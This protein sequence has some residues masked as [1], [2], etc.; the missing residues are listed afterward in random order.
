[1]L[2]SNKC[3]LELEKITK[4][5][6]IPAD[7]GSKGKSRMRVFSDA[8]LRSKPEKKENK[9]NFKALNDISFSLDQGQ[10]LGIIGLNGSG[11]STLLQIISGTLKP[12]AGIVKVKNKV[13]ALL[14]LGAGFNPDFTGIENIFINAQLLGLSVKEIKEG[15]DRIIGFADIGDFVHQPVRTYSSG[16]SVRLAFAIVANTRPEIL[17]IDEALAVGDARF[18]AKCF[19][20]LE[21]FTQN[22][23]TLILVSHDLNSI[24]RLCSKVVL[25]DKGHLVFSGDPLSAINEYS[26]IITRHNVDGKKENEPIKGKGSGTKESG[27]PYDVAAKKTKIENCIEH[28]VSI[29]SS[30]FCYGGELGILKDIDLSTDSEKSI[31]VIQSGEIFNLTFRA[32]A[33]HEI[34][35]PIFAMTI[36]DSK[37]QEVYGQNTNFAKIETD[38]LKPGEEVKVSFTQKA[39]FN[40][41]D[42]LISVG[43]TKFNEKGLEVIHR[44]YDV[45]EFKVINRDGSFGISNCF[46]EILIEK[47][48]LCGDSHVGHTKSEISFKLED[49]IITLKEGE[50][51]EKKREKCFRDLELE[52]SLELLNQVS[53]GSNWKEVVQENF[54][55][56]HPWLCDIILNPNRFNFLKEKS[57]REKLILDIGSGWGQLSVP[58]AKDNYVCSLEPNHERLS[59][60][61]EV[62]KQEEVIDKMHFI[63]ADY[64]EVDFT[65][66]FDVILSV[67]VLEWV[68]VFRSDISPE[69][70]QL[71]FLEKVKKDL[72][73]QG[74]LILGIENRIGLKYILGANDDH[75]GVPEI[76]FLGNDLAKLKYKDLTNKDLRTFTYSLSEYEMLLKKAGFKTIEFTVAYP[77]YKIPQKLFPIERKKSSFNEF[78]LREEWI[79]EHDGSNGER[80]PFQRELRSMYSTLAHN[81]IAHYFAPS[82]Y[83]VAS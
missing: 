48:K 31:K 30:G 16:M 61:R 58:L 7:Y 32:I 62:A 64:F 37:G 66:T 68:G 12:S 51:F 19:S 35:K 69:D 77:D 24:S 70:V 49:R 46:S 8:L 38:L 59:F 1:M 52:K 71:R 2:L 39:N 36:R 79:D 44:M 74:N 40:S 42:Y 18:Q 4:I 45:I 25:L 10:S 76:A 83:I 57:Y 41:G 34:D 72:S 53:N 63:G 21:K 11:K 65:K 81:G 54:K 15:L 23:G 20:F 55:E 5:F 27:S 3:V 78:I 28:S 67:G 75:L 6:P 14:E 73:P 60:V 26:K 22:G 50:S 33:I 17:I 82:F 56:N 43:F 9:Q 29:P 80:L 13:A 47:Y